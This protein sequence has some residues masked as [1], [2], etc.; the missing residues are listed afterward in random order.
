[1]TYVPRVVATEAALALIQQLQ[2]KH[3]PILFHQSGGCCEGS[4]PMCFEVGDFYIGSQDVKIGEV[5][6]AA[7]WM[8][9]SQFDYWKHTQLI[10]DAGDGPSGTFSIESSE[11]KHFKIDSRVF[12]EEER[13][14]LENQPVETN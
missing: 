3:G 12:T 9:T 13:H 14:I 1:M 11:N 2:E 7:F 6:G 5:G 4:V 8:H 10:L